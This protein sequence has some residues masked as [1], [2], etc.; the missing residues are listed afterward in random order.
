MLLFIILSICLYF[1][2][3]SFHSSKNTYVFRGYPCN[4]VAD[5]QLWL[6]SGQYKNSGG[7]LEWCIDKYDAE[8]LLKEMKKDKNFK[9]LEI[10]K[11]KKSIN[12]ILGE[13]ITQ[14]TN[15]R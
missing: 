8:I 14:K 4:I 2:F 5:D 6:I 10:E 9:N 11:F 12:Q 1:S 13:I 3:I 7:I 15:K